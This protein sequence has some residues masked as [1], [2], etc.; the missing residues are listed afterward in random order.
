[1]PNRYLRKNSVLKG[2]ICIV[3]FT[4]S[5]K[6]SLKSLYDNKIA[7]FR[8]ETGKKK[9]CQFYDILTLFPGV[10]IFVIRFPLHRNH[11]LIRED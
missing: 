11:Y 6:K 7:N 1:M 2:Q 8:P 4:L 3:K 5:G 10:K 9:E